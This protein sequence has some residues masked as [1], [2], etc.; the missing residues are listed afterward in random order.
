MA[1]IRAII[2]RKT[3]CA[4][5]SGILG[6]R[7]VNLGQY[8]SGGDP[9]VSLQSLDPIYVEF[10]VPQQYVGRVAPRRAPISIESSDLGSARFS[11][12]IT[13]INSVVD[14]VTR[15]IQ[16]QATLANPKGRLRPGMFVETQVCWA[17]PSV[18][19]LCPAPAISYAPYGDSVFVVA[20]LKDH[21][22]TELSGRAPAV[23]EAGDRRA[24][25]RSQFFPA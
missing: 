4:P 3:I 13:A 6:I 17:R 12:Q 22:R 23:R 20:D 25:I 19:S 21:E 9:I 16:I 11:G 8:L 5:F 15:N 1:E 14:E 18:S 2:A 10:C 7:Q 24:A